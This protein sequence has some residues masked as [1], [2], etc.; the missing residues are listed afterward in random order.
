M[1][2]PTGINPNDDFFAN[3]GKKTSAPADKTSAPNTPSNSVDAAKWLDDNKN[4][5]SS[6]AFKQ[7]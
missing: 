4:S 6:I 3:Y 1:I 2:S 5:S 7:K